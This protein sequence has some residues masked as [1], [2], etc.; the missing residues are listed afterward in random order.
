MD[1]DNMNYFNAANLEFGYDETTTNEAVEN[2]QTEAKGWQNRLSLRGFANYLLMGR[3]L[4]VVNSFAFD[5]LEMVMCSG[6]ED[7]MV[8]LWNLSGLQP[9]PQKTLF[10]LIANSQA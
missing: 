10:I 1:I 7:G 3:H 2:S 5:D 8:K 4:D 9:T 6:S